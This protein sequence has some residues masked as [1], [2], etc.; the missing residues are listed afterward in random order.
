MEVTVFTEY[1]FNRDGDGVVCADGVNRAYEFWKN[2]LSAFDQVNVVGR[3]SET[4][5]KDDGLPVEGPGVKVI[6]VPLFVGVKQFLTKARSVGRVI[7]HACSRQSSFI[8]RVPGTLGSVAYKYLRADGI[9]FAAEVVGDPVGVF[10]PGSMRHP[11]RPV[12]RPILKRN[13]SSLTLHACGASYVTRDALQRLYPCPAHSVA[14]ADV[15]LPDEA[16]VPQPNTM[17]SIARTSVVV[18]VG[19][20]EQLYKGPDVLLLAAARC[21]DEQF[22]IRVVLVGEGKYESALRDQAAALR[23]QDQVDFRGGLPSGSPVRAV[24]D[25]ADLF[26][27]PSRTEGMPRA[28]LEAMARGLPCIASAVGG[29]PELLP[30]E[31]MVPSGDSDALAKKMITVLSSPARM[32]VMAERNLRRARDYHFAALQKRREEFY[33]FVRC[34]TQEWRRGCHEAR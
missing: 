31:D 34:R 4:P 20:L 18:L 14:V 29:I 23:I 9:P 6:P 28:L 2:Y 26:V 21:R 7:R 19:S 25:Q 17:S 8:L 15:Y 3:V 33:R 22:P 30:E 24:L 13:L 11:L 16:F 10:A 5:R 12:L 1:R 27:L 32:H